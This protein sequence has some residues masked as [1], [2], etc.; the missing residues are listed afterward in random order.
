MG[1]K[2][3]ARVV[4]KIGAVAATAAIFPGL[5]LSAPAMAAPS[6]PAVPP[7]PQHTQAPA[8]PAAPRPVQ[9]Q[10]PAPASPPATHAPA[11]ATLTAAPAP[12]A[13]APKPEAPVTNSP[14]TAAPTTPAAPTSA[15][16][17]AP[18]AAHPSTVAPAATD[19]PA[20]GHSA[21]A[22]TAGPAAGG[23]TPAPG[24]TAT[25]PGGRAT[26]PSA[27]GGVGGTAAATA[28]GHDTVAARGSTTAT[29]PV[30]PAPQ[31]IPVSDESVRSARL[32]AATEVKPAEPPPVRADFNAQVQAAVGVNVDHD[33]D[34][35]RPRHW[36]YVDY[37]EYHRP[38]FYNPLTTDMSF[39]YF[40][41]GDYRTVIVPAGGHVVLDVDAQG[42]FP[43]TA[44]AGAY[45]AVGSFYGGAW[46]PPVGWVGPPPAD[47]SP[48][49]PVVYTGVPVD[50]ADTGQTVMV[51]KVTTVG[52]DDS[53]PP[54]QQDVF[55]LNDSTLARGT[56]QPSLAGGPPQVTLQQTQPLPGVSPWDNGQQ[57][58]NTAIK[59]PVTPANNR[60]PW[61]IGGLAA[62]LALIGGLVAWIWRH[63]RGDHALANAPTEVV[64]PPADWAAYGADDAYQAPGTQMWRKTPAA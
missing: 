33:A 59:K 3:F 4:G 36:D 9:A 44:V 29:P 62:V 28:G 60:L 5:L 47:W 14:V 1:T 15:A 46:L 31:G 10:A 41:D 50:V 53:L 17:V 58:V 23:T 38:N 6:T 30:A 52:H 48:W 25:V 34:V 45:V 12:T 24:G 8:P 56:I 2:P 43:F 55:L 21:T 26:E 27:E 16:P 37:D 11:P 19:S 49:Q 54:G 42:V 18:S 13:A 22:T 61:I 32:A 35:Y 63:P 57:Y 40:Y 7:A 39:R 20:P 51:D 64:N